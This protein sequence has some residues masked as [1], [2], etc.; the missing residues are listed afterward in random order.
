MADELEVVALR[1]G[2]APV[3]AERA[4]MNLVELSV[5]VLGFLLPSFL[6]G[7]FIGHKTEPW[8]GMLG[9]LGTLALL[10]IAFFILGAH[11]DRKWKAKCSVKD[12][13]SS[14]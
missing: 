6:I 14:R 2:D 5:F 11:N 10:L 3:I 1:R 8:I 9:G 13:S 12:K 4:Q 7:R